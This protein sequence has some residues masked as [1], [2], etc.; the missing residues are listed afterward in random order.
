MRANHS[1]KA[2]EHRLKVRAVRR[3]DLGQNLER[4]PHNADG[5]IQQHAQQRRDQR[6][7][8]RSQRLGAAQV[9]HQ[10][11]LE[12]RRP[13][14]YPRRVQLRSENIDQR[15]VRKRKR[16]RRHQRHKMLVALQRSRSNF[17]HIRCHTR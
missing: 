4:E 3:S 15:P 8:K 5:A 16:R 6:I 1:E 2:R 13:R 7:D 11:P 14:C 9:E 12:R 17:F 10:Q